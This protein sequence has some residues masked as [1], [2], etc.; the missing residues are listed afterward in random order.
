MTLN[1]LSRPV[2]SRRTFLRAARSS[3]ALPMLNA[4]LPR[5]LR[6][7]ERAAAIKPRRL[8]LVARNLGLHAPFLF[9]EKTGLDYESTRYL[10]LL[11]EHRGSF[12]LFSGHVP[13]GL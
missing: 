8:V 3:I 1:N 11:D 12:T 10:K 6:A 7:A 2:L 13:P 5:T 4:M 9:P